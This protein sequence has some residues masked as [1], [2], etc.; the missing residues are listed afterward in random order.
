MTV[1]RTVPFQ[2]EGKN[3]EIRVSQE[4]G[5]IC[6]RAYHDDKHANGYA[7]CVDVPTKFGFSRSKGFSQGLSAIENLI[8]F[9]KADVQNKYW[10]RY[11][12]AYDALQQENS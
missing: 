6:V 3:Y 8:E 11:L 2:F 5:Q 7:Y 10:E 12:A 9:A 1:L 4:A